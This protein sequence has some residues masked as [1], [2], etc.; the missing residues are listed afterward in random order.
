MSSEYR[1]LVSEEDSTRRERLCVGIGVRKFCSHCEFQITPD[2]TS[3]S[4]RISISEIADMN[5]CPRC[6]RNFDALQLLR[7]TLAELQ[8]WKFP[9]VCYCPGDHIYW[10]KQKLSGGII[11]AECALCKNE[12]HMEA[13]MA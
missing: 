5:R 11:Q 1:S 4:A 7:K 10:A 8:D 13:E 12:T 9:P 3:D 6:L 2:V